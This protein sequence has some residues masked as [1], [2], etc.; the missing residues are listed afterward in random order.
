MRKLI[1]AAPVILAPLLL[2]LAACEGPGAAGVSVAAGGPGYYDGY[3]DGF[4]GPFN[5]GYWG[6]DG[7]FW[8]SDARHAFHRDE[9]HHFQRTASAGFNHVRGTGMPRQH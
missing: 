8:Y 7:F 2:A 6:N 1:I 5:D 9:G 4:Y 3:Y